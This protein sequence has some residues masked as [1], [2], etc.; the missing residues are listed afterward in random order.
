MTL[1]QLS[2]KIHKLLLEANA[3]DVVKIEVKGLTTL[4]DHMFI[5]T[6]KARPHN[7]AI[8]ET[9][10]ESLKEDGVKALGI[11]GNTDAEWILLDYGE[12]VVHVMRKNCRDFYALEKLWGTPLPVTEEY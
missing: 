8:V 3:E 1:E 2:E 9:I 6:G 4:F 12:V 10:V 5:A 7:R 11:E